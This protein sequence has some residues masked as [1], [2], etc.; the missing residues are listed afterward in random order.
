MRIRWSRTL[1][2]SV[3]LL[4]AALTGA[5]T[6]MALA[7][8]SADDPRPAIGGWP[9]DANGDQVISDSG[10]ERIPELI[11]A[12]GD[13]GAEGYVRYEDL[14]GPQPSSP[15]EALKMSGQQRVIPVYAGDG[16]TVVDQYTITS[17]DA[18]TTEPT[19]TPTPTES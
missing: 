2:L 6:A 18:T 12:V 10:D 5:G 8:G 1:W 9:D 4:L 13:H 3:L 19:P 16:K 7:S 14:E 15:E 11:R 17:G